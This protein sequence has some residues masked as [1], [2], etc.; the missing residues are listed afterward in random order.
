M[1]EFVSHHGV[2][3][4]VYSPV[5]AQINLCPVLCGLSS[6]VPSALIQTPCSDEDDSGT[7]AIGVNT[8]ICYCQSHTNCV[9]VNL[10]AGNEKIL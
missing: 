2:C 6:H 3:C 10:V 7:P 9:E 5:H 4:C 8:Y 1:K